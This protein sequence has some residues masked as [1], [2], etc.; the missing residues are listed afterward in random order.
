[1]TGI[2]DLGLYVIAGPF[3]SVTPRRDLVHIAARL[4]SLERT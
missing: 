3:V 1:M 2:H 4:A